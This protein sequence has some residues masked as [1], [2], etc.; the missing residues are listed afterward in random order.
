LLFVATGLASFGAF[1]WVR[2]RAASEQA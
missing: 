1:R 2:R